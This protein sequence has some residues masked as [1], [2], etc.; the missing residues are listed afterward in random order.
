[1]KI[2]GIS[3]AHS[4]CGKTE[5]ACIL[6]RGLSSSSSSSGWG[7]IKCTREGLYAS[8][9]DDPAVL[10]EHGKDTERMIGAGASEVLWVRASA[11]EMAEALDIALPRMA[12]L[13]GVVVEGNRAVE[14]LNPDI[15]IFVMG[16]GGLSGVK[17]GAQRLMD[18]AQVILSEGGTIRHG[19]AASFDL[20]D[21]A[22]VAHV[23]D[24]VR[25]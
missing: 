7:A 17:P 22:W 15:V 9:I 24:E 18:M 6:L 12:H 2:I 3:G 8:V 10:G 5:A 19:R 25:K 21:K 16:S 14:V 11:E 4:G 13:E 20:H 23:L 1:M